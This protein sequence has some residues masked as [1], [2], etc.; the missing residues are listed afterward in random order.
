[1]SEGLQVK[2]ARDVPWSSDKEADAWFQVEPANAFTSHHH[3]ILLGC[4]VDGLTFVR[5]KISTKGLQSRA[6]QAVATN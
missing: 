2:G 6:S 5:S 3:S 1:M 4:H